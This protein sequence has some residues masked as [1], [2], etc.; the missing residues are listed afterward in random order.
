MFRRLFIF[1]ERRSRC[2]SWGYWIAWTLIFA[3][4]GL[5]LW[6][7]GQYGEFPYLE[8]NFE[9]WGV[10]LAAFGLLV[11]W[12]V[13][14]RR[15]VDVG[16]TK[17]LS[18]L[19]F[20]PIANAYLVGALAFTKSGRWNVARRLDEEGGAQCDDVASTWERVLQTSRGAWVAA[21][22][23]CAAVM[24]G[25]GALFQETSD[26]LSG[27]PA[28]VV[29]LVVMA[30]GLGSFLLVGAVVAAVL[31]FTASVVGARMSSRCLCSV[32]IVRALCRGVP[33][34]PRGD[35]P[36]HCSFRQVFHCSSSA[37]CTRSW[38]F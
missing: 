35:G 29:I 14:A 36:Q 20:V 26:A 7:T 25:Q 16:Q 37:P 3:C 17:L 4:T 6:L 5:P 28:P 21:T 13:C 18:F 10:V 9:P 34:Q 30:A 31:F 8:G 22:V 27:R 24:A 12:W 32:R 15:L 33:R 11:G 23:V 2:R 1:S 19:C 38:A